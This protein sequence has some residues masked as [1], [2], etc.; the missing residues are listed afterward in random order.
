MFKITNYN[1]YLTFSECKITSLS[2]VQSRLCFNSDCDY[3][4]FWV[5]LNVSPPR[6]QQVISHRCQA[7]VRLSNCPQH[8]IV[9]IS[10]TRV[11]DPPL[12]PETLHSLHHS[13]VLTN[14]YSG[15]KAAQALSVKR[16]RNILG[17]MTTSKLLE[18]LRSSF[19]ASFLAYI[20]KRGIKFCL[21]VQIITAPRNISLQ[22]ICN[23]PNTGN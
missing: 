22:I 18:L 7:E 21:N 16:W 20:T 2:R 15:R 19:V 5:P 8:P 10:G 1:I 14:I 12:L 3:G 23:L 13:I 6:F 11:A 4:S 9:A 17:F